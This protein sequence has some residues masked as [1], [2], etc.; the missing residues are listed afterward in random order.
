MVQDK[1][2]RI[3]DAVIGQHKG[4]HNYTIGQRQ[5]IA[6]GGSGGPYYVVKKDLTKNILYVTNNPHHPLLE[7]NEVAIHSVNWLTSPNLS[8]HKERKQGLHNASIPPLSKGRLGGVK[9]LARYR[10]QGALVPCTVQKLKRD[11]YLIK[12]NMPQK[13]L[14]SG[15]SV[16]F[17]SG[18]VCLGGG[19]IA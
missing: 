3:K 6:V 9:L 12:F 18:K 11:Q 16:V 7:V 4:L 1:R 2:L 14:A 8:L 19:I 15:Q 5:G 17:Y 13:A 10:H